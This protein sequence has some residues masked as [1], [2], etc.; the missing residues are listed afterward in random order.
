MSASIEHFYLNPWRV[1]VTG[2]EFHCFRI[3]VSMSILRGEGGLTVLVTRV[4]VVYPTFL[5]MQYSVWYWTLFS[6]YSSHG[7]KK[8]RRSTHQKNEETNSR[9]RSITPS[10]LRVVVAISLQFVTIPDMIISIP[11]ASHTNS[12]IQSLQ[13]LFESRVQPACASWSGEQ[14]RI[15]WAYYPKAVKTNEIARSVIIMTVVLPLQQ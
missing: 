3:T 15:S 1:I 7:G 9:A 2:V 8:F 5:L 10:P 6:C 4:G 11:V 14:S 12:C 13:S